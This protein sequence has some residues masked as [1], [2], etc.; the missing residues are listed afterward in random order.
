MNLH[1]N[2]DYF[3]NRSE[4]SFNLYNSIKDSSVVKVLP[5]DI[6]CNSYIKER[7]TIIFNGNSFYRDYDHLSS[8]G[9]ELLISLLIDN[10]IENLKN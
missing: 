7:C 2:D 3:Y 9:N 6:F 10:L 1:Y 4:N 5:S 8:F